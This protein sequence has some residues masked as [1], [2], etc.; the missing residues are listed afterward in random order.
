M[1]KLS[2][3]TILTT[4][5]YFFEL[6]AQ[7]TVLSTGGDASG[8]GG[9]SSYSI[10]QVVYTTNSGTTGSVAQGVQQPYEISTNVGI[11]INEISLNIGAY[12]NPTNTVLTLDIGKYI[13][14]KLT[15]QLYNLKG[16]LLKNQQVI[17]STTQIAVKNLYAGTYLLNIQHNNSVIKSFRIVKN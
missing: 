13:E 7:E 5:S 3:I 9:S 4:I 12:P 2:L 10:G 14:E 8:S 11:K 6:H 1:R 16:Q 15:Y 17:S